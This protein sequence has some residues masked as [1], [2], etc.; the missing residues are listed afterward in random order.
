ML[1]KPLPGMQVRYDHPLMRGLV[2]WWLFNEGGGSRVNDYSVYNNAGTVANVV[3]GS[4]SGWTGS[5]KGGQALRF[6]GVNDYL[7][8]PHLPSYAFL[9]PRT[10]TISFWVMF[11]TA[12]GATQGVLTKSGSSTQATTPFGVW[13]TP[14]S[15]LFMRGNNAGDARSVSISIP[16]IMTWHHY[17]FVDTGSSLLAY[18]DGVLV[19]NAAATGITFFDNGLPLLAGV[20]ATD[21]SFPAT[22]KLDDLRLFN[23]ALSPSTIASIYAD[24]WAPFQSTAWSLGGL[25]GI[26][27]DAVSNSGYQAAQSS[28][29]FN[30]TCSGTDR[31]LTVDI[32]ILSAGQTVVS[33]IDDFGG[34]AVAMTLI[35]V[36]STV[37][38]FG[39]I[40]SWGL[41]APVTG[42][43]SIQVNLS[44]VVISSSM[45]VSYTGVHQSVPTEAFNS[46]QGTNVGAT[47]AT[48]AVTSIAS[49][50]WIHAAVATDDTVITAGQTA[51]NN[52]TGAGGSGADEDT[53]PVAAGVTN[54]HYTAV[55][56]LATWAITGYAIRPVAASGGAF[57][58]T[59]AQGSYSITGQVVGLLSKHSAVAG[60]GSYALSGQTVTL[61]RKYTV[62]AAQGSYTLS[63]QAVTLRKGLF[64]TNSSGLYV[65]S[66]Q[67]LLFTINR[68]ITAQVGL[69]TL[70]GQVAGL[71]WSNPP[72]SL[73]ESMYPLYRRRGRE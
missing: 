52:V 3:Q 39:R 35:G 15:M 57:A 4:A 8:I 11:F 37:T 27:I 14:G 72:V 42:S 70:S 7:T 1:T 49:N 64:I 28:Y 50:C 20:L 36:R 9:S 29:T 33:V 23:Q 25:A 63:G 41:V 16:L 19:S 68:A 60:Q 45:A 56:A 51:R 48:V 18:L 5:V 69:Y 58:L 2:G 53:G 59:T 26:A 21:L 54:M 6:D 73:G 66:G 17:A 24:P 38:S 44:G 34:A 10:M 22:L 65:L 62:V 47:D 30:R 67:D 32:A 55:A 12:A 71:T 13:H 40:E 46:N 43:K 31:F 61:L